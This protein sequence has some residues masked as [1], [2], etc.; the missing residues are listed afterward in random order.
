VSID[1]EEL[2]VAELRRQASAVTWQPAMLDRVLQRRRKRLLRRR[3]MTAA[4]TICVVVGLLAVSVS[5]AMSSRG[6][7]GARA[8]VQTV[9]YVLS[10]ARSAVGAARQDVLEVHAQFSNGWSYTAWFEPATGQS[11]IDVHPPADSP[12]FYYFD[13][14]RTIIVNYQTQTYSTHS[15]SVQWRQ[16]LLPVNVAWGGLATLP[17]PTAIRRALAA[18]SFQRVGTDTVG[19]RRLLHFRGSDIFP[20]LKP[21]G[22]GGYHTLDIWINATTYLP[23]RSVTGQGP[24]APRMRSTF[25]WLPATQENLAVFTPKIPPGF[26]HESSRLRFVRLFRSRKAERLSQAD[27]R[28]PAAEACPL[29]SRPGPQG[30]PAIEDRKW[31]AAAEAIDFDRVAAIASEL[32]GKTITR[33]TVS[34]DDYRTSLVGH[35]VPESAADILLGI[36]AAS[37]AGEFA[38]VDPTLA[39]LLGRTPTG[40]EAYLRDEI[41]SDANA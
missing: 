11:R 23:V 40:L 12:V 5:A 28:C 6:I 9:A 14:S 2:L 32:T 37:R 25:S 36:F 15:L 4:G 17:T 30:A 27:H 19:G 13:H 7:P 20:Q 39:T 3:A 34:D 22:G 8:K 33:V 35:G 1:V 16:L 24:Y 26:R 38:A 21:H 31:R 18:R 41:A 10:R 29:A